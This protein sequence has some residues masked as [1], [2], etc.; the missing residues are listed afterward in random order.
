MSDIDSDKWF[1]DMKSEMDSMGSNQVWALVDPPK[2]VRP[3]GRKWVYKRKLR[4][5]GRLQPSRLGS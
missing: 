4:A 1:E 5:D 3:V 2:G